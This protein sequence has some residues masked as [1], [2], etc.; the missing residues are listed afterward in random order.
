MLSSTLW[1][2]FTTPVTYVLVLI[3]L[4][5]AIMQIRYVN[6][7][8]QRFDSTQV[9]PIQFVL[10][11]LCVILGSA[12][13][14]RD[15]EK[16]TAKQAGKFV[17]GCLLTFFGVFLVTSGREQSEDDDDALSEAEGVEETIGLAHQEGNQQPPT[18]QQ[19]ITTPLSRSRRSSRHSRVGYSELTRP[20]S[21][22]EEDDVPPFRHAGHGSTP[23]S[24]G[25]ESTSL[26]SNPWAQTQAATPPGRGV[27]TLSADTLMR[28]SAVLTPSRSNP[29]TPMRN[30]QIMPGYHADQPVTPQGRA[31]TFGPGQHHRSGTFISPS[32]LAS[33]VTT[34][35]KDG[36]L[37]DKK[38]LPQKSSMRHLRSRIRASLFFNEGENGGIAGSAGVLTSEDNLAQ[39]VQQ[40]EDQEF[41][42]TSAERDSG[43]IRSRSLSDTLGDF[44]KPKK[45][46]KGE[47]NTDIEQGDE[48][49]D[50]QP[51]PSN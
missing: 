25:P 31:N 49:T 30:G 9:I 18:V 42:G 33:T 39:G 26:L 29:A 19:S 43:R 11:T 1:R 15:F 44:F 10:F 36:F 28:G 46:R 6:K 38:T 41:H 7:A 40:E 45:R 12:V 13:L 16:T 24:L 3:L 2:A 22:D 23:S 27:R 8:L 17:G 14:Y 32:P 37:R 21:P 47:A 51:G 20:Y 48:D 4:G 34:V 50:T 35:M 5:T